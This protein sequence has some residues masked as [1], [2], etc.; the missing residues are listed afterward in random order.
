MLIGY[1][2][3]AG[4]YSKPFIVLALTILRTSSGQYCYCTHLTEEEMEAQREVLETGEPELALVQ[5]SKASQ[6]WRYLSISLGM[7]TKRPCHA[8][9][10][11]LLISLIWSGAQALM[12]LLGCFNIIFM[13]Y[14]NSESITQCTAE[15]S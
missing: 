7:F 1:L 3:C 2:K 9:L 5:C 8:L 11:K 6:P 15:L 13:V 14:Y 10:S 12:F 4:K